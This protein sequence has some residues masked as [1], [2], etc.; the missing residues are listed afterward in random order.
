MYIDLFMVLLS[1]RLSFTWT[2]AMLARVFALS[3]NR[4][5]FCMFLPLLASAY[6]PLRS[7]CS[8]ALPGHS[9][10]ISETVHM[11]EHCKHHIMILDHGGQSGLD[12]GKA[13]K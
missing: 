9:C 13:N 10:K 12:C 6:N 7:Q 1:L 2:C 3:F 5:A 11:I 8:S 4:D